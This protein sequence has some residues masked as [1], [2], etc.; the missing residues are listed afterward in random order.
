MKN[1]FYFKNWNYS[2]QH[3]KTDPWIFRIW[4]N[5]KNM[6]QPKNKKITY[7]TRN[8]KVQNCIRNNPSNFCYFRHFNKLFRWLLWNL[9]FVL[10]YFFIH[11]D[12]IMIL[13]P[14]YALEKSRLKWAHQNQMN[15]KLFDIHKPK[16]RR[17]RYIYE[18]VKRRYMINI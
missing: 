16:I 14:Y 7:F 9:V 11:F 10:K 5:K 6:K 17:L 13:G 15:C 12:F 4:L 1:K 18:Q 3:E 2:L 8:F